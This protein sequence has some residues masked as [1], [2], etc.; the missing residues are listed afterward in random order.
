[1]KYVLLLVL[2]F[3]FINLIGQDASDSTTFLQAMVKK[4]KANLE[5]VKNFE[6][7][8]NMPHPLFEWPLK[9]AD[10]FDDPGV[11]A[12]SNFVDQT[13]GAGISDY[14]GGSRTY[15]THN[16]IDI[17]LAPFRWNKMAANQVEVVAG[18]DGT[19]TDK[20][21]GNFDQNCDSDTLPWNFVEITHFDGSR[22]IYGHLK[23]GSVTG[24]AIGET[25]ETGDFLG[26][27]GS[28]GRSSS[29]HLHFMVRDPDGNLI[30]PFMGPNNSLNDDTWWANQLPYFDSGV[31]KIMTS[32]E[33]YIS[34]P[35]PALWTLFEEDVFE[36]EDPIT[37]SIHL[38]NNLSGNTSSLR[39]FDPTGS[40]A[41]FFSAIYNDDNGF[42]TELNRR[43]DSSIPSDAPIGKWTFQLQYETPS[44][45]TLTIEKKFW[46]AN[47]CVQNNIQLAGLHNVDRYYRS[48][49][50]IL[51]DAN[52]PPGIHTIYDANE[53]TILEPGFKAVTGSKFEV[54]T[55]GCN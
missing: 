50:T 21:D 36:R 31:N 14:L 13:S 37:F 23:Q 33:A 43:W 4:D 22:S 39:V 18:A 8:Q 1:M 45:G 30:D 46:V 12:I 26:L 28:S 15:D 2:P 20:E 38:R 47:S 51:S 17:R 10:G 16:G 3:C 40:Q 19:I 42:S 24:K 32:T 9:Q 55:N 34:N 44:S 48:N 7:Q 6:R 5:K 54:K 53:M 25:V 41:D 35:C 27:V 49:S 11:Y 52:V 29:P